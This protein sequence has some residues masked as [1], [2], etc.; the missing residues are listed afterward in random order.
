MDEITRRVGLILNG[1]LE[2]HE[3]SRPRVVAPPA[4]R[5]MVGEHL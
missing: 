3:L 4:D 1:I 2:R 5:A